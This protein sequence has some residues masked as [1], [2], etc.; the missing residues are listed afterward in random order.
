MKH[1]LLFFFMILPLFAHALEVDEKLTVRIIKTS[2]SRKTIMVNRGIEDGLVEGDHARFIVTAGIVARAV[3]V[4]V[5][6]TRS[7]W[8]V[9]RLVNADFIVNDSVMSLKITPPVKITK[10]SSQALVREDVPSG[11][12]SNPAELGIPLADGAQDLHNGQDE[13][14]D[15]DLMSLNEAE[16]GP[17]L[18]EKNIEVFGI[19]NISGLTSETKTEVTENSFTNSQAYHHIALGGEYYPRNEREW[20]SRFSLIASVNF[21]RQNNQ[22]Y[23][24]AS[25]TNDVN[26]VSAGINWHWNKP[27][28]A[29]T[30]IPFIHASVSMGAV[31]SSFQPGSENTA[32]EEVSNTGSTNG[33][34]V[35][36]GYK[37]YTNRGFGARAMVDYYFR[38]ETYEEDDLNNSYTKAVAGPRLMIGLS[39]RF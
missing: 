36:F 9:Y 3:C 7:V 37:F 28:L 38:N 22:A 4:R 17:Q 20:Y 29:F 25:S 18:V 11:T 33:V 8:S 35:G 19:L 15:S 2:E 10:D 39:Y 1:S 30:F 21:M 31:K 6:P 27:S 32:G 26:E 13:G 16:A 23:N 14:A 34:S 5:S 24:G 12:P